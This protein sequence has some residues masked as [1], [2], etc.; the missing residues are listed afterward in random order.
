MKISTFCIGTLALAL[1]FSACQNNASK[2]DNSSMDM[3][4]SS[5][6]NM[7]R[8]ATSSGIMGAMDK[9]M[10]DMHQMEMTG[11]ADYDLISMLKSHHQ[12]AID[13]AKIELESGTEP[14][15]KQIAQNIVDKQSK[16]IQMLDD[17][18]KSADKSKK[19]Y[20]PSDKNS[21]LGKDMDANM[22]KMM[23]MDHGTPGSLDHEFASMMIKHHKDG[24][25]MDNIIV[26]HSK[27]AE[28]KSMAQK[29]I[30]D[31]TK[32]IAELETAMSQH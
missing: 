17:M 12:G 30:D 27:M 32:E 21:G 6:M 14:K 16:E 24:I 13:M 22:M 5:H 7:D 1:S 31:Q 26:K 8:T 18:L 23:E 3:S 15:L 10:K 20:E 4:D 28:F 19:D 2:S 9:M 11:N 25:D 29:M